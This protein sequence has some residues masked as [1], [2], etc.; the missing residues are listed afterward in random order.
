MSG[1]DA[2]DRRAA[3]ASLSPDEMERH[4]NPRAAVP[5]YDDYMRER[6]AANARAVD[7]ITGVRD[8]R[9]GP[10]EK[11]TLDIYPA[12]TTPAPVQVYIHGG[13]WRA[14]DKD[15]FA[16][17]AAPLVAGGATVVVANYDLCP[18]VSLDEIVS[19]MRRAM[20]WLY[21]NVGEYGG[22]PERIFIS[23]NSAGAHLCA[24]MLGYDWTR[25]AL[26]A[27]LI[28]GAVLITG[29]YDVHPVLRISVNNEIRLDAEAARRNSPM[30]LPP[31]HAGALLAAVGGAE[32]EGWKQQTRDYV[33]MCQTSDLVCEYL[34]LAGEN[35]F[36]MSTILADRDC[37]LIQAMLAQMGLGG[38]S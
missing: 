10:N 2:D 14:A 12:A 18:S 22:D 23:G 8:L 4:F 19:E 33:A 7:T 29:I 17:V 1:L 24:M 27:D 37:P 30:L 6:A 13:Y 36:S 21:R 16:Y 34:E 20:A 28:K 5:D 25:E 35:H 15:E 11:E 31:R 3:L 26:P 9:F 32:P 38:V